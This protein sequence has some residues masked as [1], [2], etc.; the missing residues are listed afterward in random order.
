MA[1]NEFAVPDWVYPMNPPAGGIPPPPDDRVLL[2]VPDSAAAFTRA[3]VKDL[4]AVPDW[5]A[6]SH[7]PM[8][9]VVAHGRK[10]AVY[11]CGYCHLPDGTGR[12]ENAALAGLPVEYIVAQ[13]LAIRRGERRSAS[14]EAYL[15]VEFMRTTAEYVTESDLRAAAVYFAG[16]RMMRRVGVVETDTVPVTHVAGWLHVPV[17]GGGVELLGQRIIEV[18]VDTELHELRDSQAGYVAYVP[19][20][21]V[22]RG[23]QLALRG[24]GERTLPCTGCHGA[25]LKGVGLVPPI[26]GRSPTYLLRQLVG[27]RN[28]ARSSESGRPMQPVVER[29]GIEE[30]IAVA[31]YVAT[32]EP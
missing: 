28:G 7:P 17:A 1:R 26:A 32:R 15:P 11:A 10:P 20:G 31:A 22:A 13:V 21:S 3:Q 14:Q 25:D 30:M 27:F 12:P 29:L 6:Q 23:E 2:R 9:E 19:S 16:L 8:P 4:F 18:P 24:G 5:H